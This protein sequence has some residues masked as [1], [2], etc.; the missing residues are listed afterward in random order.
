M[1]ILL[2]LGLFALNGVL[3]MSETS[4]VSS[5]KMRL[6]GRADAGSAGARTAL[7]LSENPTRFLSTVQIGITLIGIMS[8]AIGEASVADALEAR[9]REIPSVAPYAGQVALVSVV[10]GL[11]FCSVVVGELIPKRLAMMNPEAVASTLA[12]PL[13]TLSIVASPAVLLLSSITD[14][15]LFP[16]RARL[17]S[18][19]TVTSA[20]INILV[21]EG[22]RAGEFGPEEQRLI[23]RVLHLGDQR[24]DSLMVHRTEM[25]WFDVNTPLEKARRIARGSALS[26]FPVCKG[27]VDRVVGVVSIRDLLPGEA[28]LPTDLKSMLRPPVFVPESAPALRV[29][30]RCRQAGAPAAFIVDEYGAVQGEA[31]VERILDRLVG[32]VFSGERPA[33][34]ASKPSVPGACGPRR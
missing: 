23:E 28:T 4:M 9:L 33:P 18:K 19:G 30:D 16:F 12:I 11:T 1:E 21:Q 24:I 6:R 2:I 13:R 10:V 22:A 32:R 3:A 7:A 14:F 15:V 20:E 34:G 8:G 31:T 5:Q 25:T 29:L 27:T 26:H 17:S